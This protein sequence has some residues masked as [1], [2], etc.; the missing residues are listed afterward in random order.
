VLD[1]R[2]I[3]EIDRDAVT[4][5]FGPSPAEGTGPALVHLLRGFID[6]GGIGEVVR[7]HLA[8]RFTSRRLV[9]FDVDQLLD[10]RS[11]RATMTFDGSRWAAYEEP[12]LA[13]DYVTDAEGTGFLVLSGPEP[14]LQWERF[15]AA[16]TQV[17]DELG[18]SLVATAHGVPMAVP[19][20]RAST[21]TVHATRAELIGSAPSWF[22]RAEVPASAAALLELR[23]GESGHDAVGYA[24]HV[25][26]YVAQTPYLPAAVHALRLL[27]GAT[28]LELDAGALAERAAEALD[29]VGRLV[30]GS[31]ELAALVHGLEQQY[32][33]FTRSASTPGL[34]AEDAALPTADEIGAELER[35]LAQHS[36]D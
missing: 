19:H 1:P 4:Q 20:T 5:T 18:V 21:A 23:L 29:E 9:T 16:V 25:P 7:E 28:G 26:H 27:Q 24:L 15:V 6:A 12:E 35:F 11:K 3:Y 34:L 31:D 17:V 8:E 36:D 30:E 10:Y 2:G 14:D 22:G 13:I 33:S 32:D